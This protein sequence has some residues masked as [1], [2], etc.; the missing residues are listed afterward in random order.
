MADKTTGELKSVKIGDLPAVP[1]LYDDALIPV[2]QQNEAR[3]ITGKQFKDY[4]VAAGL[5]ASGQFADSVSQYSNAA[6]AAAET[7]KSDASKANESKT[8]AENAAK[9]AEMARNSIVLDELTIDQ[10][11]SAASASAAAAKTSET[12][13][14][15]SATDANKAASRAQAEAERVSVPA[16]SGVYN[17][18]LTDRI[19][20]ERY[21]LL[22]ENGALVILGV[23]ND[24]EATDMKFIDN[25]TG[26]AYAVAVE[27]GRLILVEV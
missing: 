24:L 18:I 13:A 12:N 25:A 23:A 2:Q 17:V 5:T 3:R 8:Y 11:L 19:T 10:K 20:N 14:V 16:A 7:A 26:T 15:K 4:A 6:I 1:D 27:S 9:R 21:A 22:V